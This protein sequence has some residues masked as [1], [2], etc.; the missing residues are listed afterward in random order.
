MKILIPTPLRQYA[1]KKDTVDV[2][3]R[4]VGEALSGLTR[5]IPICAG[6]STPTTAS[7]APSSTC[8]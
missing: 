4:T 7:C 3:A 8:T 6:I 2:P 5:N 1:A